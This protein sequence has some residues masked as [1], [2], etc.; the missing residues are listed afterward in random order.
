M[1]TPAA[2]SASDV[3]TQLGA[4]LGNEVF[5]TFTP[6]ITSI[7]SDIQANPAEWTNPAS[8][9]IKGAAAVATL[10]AGLPTLEN[11]AVTGAA[12]LVQFLWLG[13]GQKIASVGNAAVAAAPAAPATPVAPPT[14]AAQTQAVG[15]TIMGALG[16]QA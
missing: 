13:I 8:A 6:T 15:A 11:S 14:V 5:S 7:L 1:S 9:A 4:L 12:S 10:T 16:G 3:L 2:P